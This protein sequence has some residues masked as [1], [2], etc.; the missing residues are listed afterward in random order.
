V[1]EQ[2]GVAVLDWHTETACN[3]YNYRN[4]LTVLGDILKPLLEDGDAWVTT[5]WEI[6][7]HW[8]QRAVGLV[9]A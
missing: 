3:A 1:K 7:Q 8:R 9:A 4:H 6:A 2:G 5:P